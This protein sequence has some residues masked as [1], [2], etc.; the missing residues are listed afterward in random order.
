MKEIAVVGSSKFVEGFRL[1]GVRKVYEASPDEMERKIEEVLKDKSVGIL[2]LRNDDMM[3]LP[4][5][6]R[7]LLSES[8]DPV[9]ISI[10]KEEEVDLRDRIRRAV[11]VDLW[12]R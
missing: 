12:R 6:L 4:K 10:G 5:Q 3:R 7:I 8:I 2:V 1:V 11:G 9:V